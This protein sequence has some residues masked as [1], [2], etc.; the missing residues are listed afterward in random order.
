MRKTARIKSKIAAQSRVCYN[1]LM[2]FIGIFGIEDDAKEL[3]VIGNIVC[4]ACGRY[5]AARLVFSY[6]FFH[7]FFIPLFKWNKTY[8]VQLK[9]CG[10]L[11][12]CDK[13]TADE[14]LRT[15]EIDF[16]KC[17]RQSP[18]SGGGGHCPYCGGRLDGGFIYCPYCGKKL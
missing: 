1:N 13:E 15:G 17:R 16:E 14:I 11:Y 4:P 18:G 10:A 2:F 9:C 7:F 12:A 5:T 6:T 3:R 8:F